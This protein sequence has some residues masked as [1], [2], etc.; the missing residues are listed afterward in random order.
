[1]PDP[2]YVISM[3]AVPTVEVFSN[4]PIRSV[5]GVDKIIPVDVYVPGCSPRPEALTRGTI[6]DSGQDYE[7]KVV[8]K[9][10]R[11]RLDL[12]I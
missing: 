10:C 3:G 12:G 9:K 2:K 7:G 1:M 5:K 11:R 4:L 6:E 8:G